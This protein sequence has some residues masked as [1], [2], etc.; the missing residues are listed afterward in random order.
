VFALL[1]EVQYA[2][3][4]EGV[5]FESTR[6]AACVRPLSLNLDGEFLL[7]IYDFLQHVENDRGELPEPGTQMQ[8]E[9]PRH[10]A[11]VM[12]DKIEVLVSTGELA[13]LSTV[14]D[15][16]IIRTAC[17]ALPSIS[18]APLVLPAVC[19]TGL[20]TTQTDLL[21]K[22]RESLTRPLL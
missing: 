12:L 1:E 5:G 9:S 20:L 14:M 19:L 13:P 11:E 16:S 17:I 6:V 7:G 18:A 4:G 15:S 21:A 2:Q 3:V 8:V 10:Y 22:F